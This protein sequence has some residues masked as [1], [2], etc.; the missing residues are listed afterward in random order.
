MNDG[1]SSQRPVTRNFDVF[2]D[3]HLDKRLSKKSRRRAHYDITVMNAMLQ[4]FMTIDPRSYSHPWGI[5]ILNGDVM[6]AST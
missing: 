1:F 6:I 5:H 3:L 4:Y 2:Y